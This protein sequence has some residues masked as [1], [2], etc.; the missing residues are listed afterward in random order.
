MIHVWQS[1]RSF[2]FRFSQIA[3]KKN[4]RRTDTSKTELYLCAKN[5]SNISNTIYYSV[6]RFRPWEAEPM[7]VY[8]CV[9]VRLN[10]HWH[11]LFWCFFPFLSRLSKWKCTTYFVKCQY[12]HPK[13]A[14]FL[15]N[16][17]SL[18]IKFYYCNFYNDP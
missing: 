7:S 6:L 1:Y 13:I 16:F 15:D 14:Q 3:D 17:F 9:C 18:A 10:Q 11:S 5:D 4:A 12:L 2:C 8:V